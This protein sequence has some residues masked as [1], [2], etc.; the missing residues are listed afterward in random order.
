MNSFEALD[1]FLKAGRDPDYRKVPSI[2]STVVHRLDDSA[3]AVQYH[4]TDVVTHYRD[5]RVSLDS[6]GWRTVTTKVRF[7]EYLPAG[8]T[9]YQEKGEWYLQRLPWDSSEP[10][11]YQD[12]ITIHPDGTVTGAAK[13]WEV[14]E[15]QNW[16]K[17]INDYSKLYA[18]ALVR[19]EVPAPSEGDCWYCLFTTVDTGEGLGDVT[20]NRD[21]LESHIR[22]RYYVPSLLDR[23]HEAF[24]GHLS[25]FAQGVIY[26]LWYRPQEEEP[27]DF[28][29]MTGIAEEQVYNLLRRYLRSRFDLAG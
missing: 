22:E 16:A 21:H 17:R 18:R 24:K 7:N 8:W 12:G 15:R 5:G 6:G 14:C 26:N 9:V 1:R 19:G 13:K 3:I 2:R 25:P 10:I 29:S 20:G 4:Q 28:G 11:P 23:A 27:H